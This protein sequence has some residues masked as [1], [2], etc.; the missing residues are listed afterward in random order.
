MIW[1]IA[2]QGELIAGFT[3]VGLREGAISQITIDFLC[4]R[5][6]TI[7]SRLRRNPAALTRG[8]ATKDLIEQIIVTAVSGKESRIRTN[9]DTK[10]DWERLV[11][12][13]REL[14]TT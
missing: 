5:I 4:N 9:P 11:R 7:G 1:R 10:K 6:E 13:V 14:T 2:S 12:K 8:R 3:V